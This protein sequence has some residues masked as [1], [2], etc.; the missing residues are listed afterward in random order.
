MRPP[1]AVWSQEALDFGQSARTLV[2]GATKQPD[3]PSW[4]ELGVVALAFGMGVGL[5]V[6]R[7]AV[8][9]AH[10]TRVRCDYAQADERLVAIHELGPDLV[11]CYYVTR[12]EF[13]SRKV[14]TD[15]KER[16][17]GH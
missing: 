16:A 1:K 11:K 5:V 6:W 2:P 17:R 15:L 3:G 13:Y 14:R 8:I 9:H 10:D 12:D 7:V 4:W